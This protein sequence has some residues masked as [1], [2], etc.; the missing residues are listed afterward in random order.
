MTNLIIFREK[1]KEFYGK[2]VIYINPII[3]FS[4]AFIVLLYINTNMGFMTVLK[5][6]ALA[7]VVA[8]ICSFLPANTII[9]VA[10]LY[11]IAHLYV[12]SLEF[13]IF[14]VA[15]F[16]IMFLLYFRFSPKDSI[17]VL[18]TPLF[19][20]LQIPFAIP[21]SAGLLGT[22]LTAIPV[23]FGTIMYY[24]ISYAKTNAVSLSN[25]ETDSMIQKFKFIIDN[26]VNNK[27][28]VLLIVTFTLTII[29]VYTIRR[30]SLDYSWN[31]AIASGSLANIILLLIGDYILEVNYSILLILFGTL[32]SALVAV[33]VQFFTFQVDYSRTEYAQFEDDEYYYYV[34]A[35]PKMLIS[36]PNKRVKR[37]NPQKNHENDFKDL[38]ND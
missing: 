19:F 38:G 6:P 18:L 7:L 27:T 37:I 32:G 20:K 21:L 31:V 16:L 2:N 28:M 17:I 5:N 24:L 11:I 1:M 13:A 14:S 25:M 3:K 26:V 23:A 33:I 22:P 35:V 12:I 4:F 29:I 8:L 10:A 15:Y 34:K 30:Q 9:I 36:Q